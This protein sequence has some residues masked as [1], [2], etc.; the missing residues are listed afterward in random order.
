MAINAQE[1]TPYA[2]PQAHDGVDPTT[3]RQVGL[4]Y[5]N[6]SVQPQT[7]IS[8][9]V[10]WV[11]SD[12]A[13][14]VTEVRMT[15]DKAAPLLGDMALSGV[16]S[17]SYQE[18]L[19][20][21]L[22]ETQ[23]NK[24]K[25]RY[26]IE[27]EIN[28][29]CT[30]LEAIGLGKTMSFDE[31]DDPFR[32]GRLDIDD[33][34]QSG[35]P[36]WR[37]SRS[38]KKRAL[39]SAE[40]ALTTIEQS[41]ELITNETIAGLNSFISAKAEAPYAKGPVERQERAI[42][43]RLYD[44]L[45]TL[46]EE[47]NFTHSDEQKACINMAKA[48]ET[49]A[50]LANGMMQSNGYD[51]IRT[52][53]YLATVVE[54]NINRYHAAYDANRARGSV[55]GNRTGDFLLL[56]AAS[57]GAE[58]SYD[59]IAKGDFLRSPQY[60]ELCGMTDT[61]GLPSELVIKEA[62]KHISRDFG[63]FEEI[64]D[65]LLAK[66]G[67]G[68]EKTEVVSALC[69][70]FLSNSI[71][72]TVEANQRRGYNYAGNVFDASYEYE[73]NQPLPVS[74]SVEPGLYL[75]NTI[76][77]LSPDQEDVLPYKQAVTE[78][79]LLHIRE[80]I[81]RPECMDITP[82]QL[83]EVVR[84]LSCLDD[85][86]R[87][88]GLSNIIS[89][90]DMVIDPAHMT[91]EQQKVK[92]LI[93]MRRTFVPTFE[94]SGS[95]GQTF[96]DQIQQYTEGMV[97]ASSAEA[98]CCRFICADMAAEY[99]KAISNMNISESL[100]KQQIENVMRIFDETYQADIQRMALYRAKVERERRKMMHELAD[101]AGGAL[102]EY[103]EFAVD[104]YA[105]NNPALTPDTID[106]EV[107][108]IKDKIGVSINISIDN[109]AKILTEPPHRFKS[110]FENA[111]RGQLDG[112]NIH[113]D[114]GEE[115]MGVRRL[116]TDM[117]SDP[118]PIYGA[119]TSPNGRDKVLGGAGAG[120]GGAFVELDV[121]HIADRTLAV[122]L[123]SGGYWRTRIMRVPLDYAARFAAINN[124]ANKK[125][126]EAIIMGGVNV[127]DIKKINIDVNDEEHART[128]VDVVHELYPEIEVAFVDRH[129]ATARKQSTATIM[130]DGNTL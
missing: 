61:V 34:T 35:T 7:R 120:F 121:D 25:N 12:E 29:V 123:D 1:T 84:A 27:R 38:A 51:G 78:D 85:D 114:L 98:K 42:K 11:D 33:H 118:Q 79:M 82:E 97:E 30:V 117:L 9:E 14:S 73:Y 62:A 74:R 4:P 16:S 130:T 102:V 45:L 72:K 95:V 47:G 50:S 77:N 93:E 53:V 115:A 83:G 80:G 88:A 46:V 13:A 90:Y 111:S 8:E 57:I 64:C 66:A 116:A 94:N 124:I 15:S 37:V 125:Y 68:G 28:E 21:Q 65:Y 60:K 17:P 20:S 108:R 19:P 71:D 119:I 6:T 104:E 41:S 75:L 105:A 39:T 99:I 101:G 23:Q 76:Q 63:D 70:G 129:E 67:T 81:L 91:A 128:L 69:E 48:V 2:I 26:H 22:A 36:S 122:P 126:P 5:P 110:T 54:A 49:S 32:R 109:L 92:A 18:E 24:E 127:S 112:Y 3:W 43:E 87:T 113:R 56:Q 59:T 86:K 31:E 106:A 100:A 52:D 55:M 107:N 40:A 10:Q 58:I 89:A 103:Q 96:I 44:R